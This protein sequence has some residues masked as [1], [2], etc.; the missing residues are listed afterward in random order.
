MTDYWLENSAQPGRHT[1]VDCGYFSDAASKARYDRLLPHIGRSNFLRVGNGRLLA[2]LPPRKAPAVLAAMPD[3]QTGAAGYCWCT[4]GF[5][6][7]ASIGAKE[8]NTHAD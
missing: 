2:R 5:V 1:L 3:I 8:G 4:H 7:A 6:A